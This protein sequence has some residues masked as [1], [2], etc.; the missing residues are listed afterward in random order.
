MW[1][2]DEDEVSVLG[3]SSIEKV[4]LC[5]ERLVEVLLSEAYVERIVVLIHHE[6]MQGDCHRGG[7]EMQGKGRWCEGWEGQGWR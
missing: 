5:C 2:L 7:W 3:V 4:Q 1:F 6:V